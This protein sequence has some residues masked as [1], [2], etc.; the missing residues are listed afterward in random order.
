MRY[1]S[2]NRVSFDETIHGSSDFEFFD[3]DDEGDDD[4]IALDVPSDDDEEALVR[5]VKR[6]SPEPPRDPAVWLANSLMTRTEAALRLARHLLTSHLAAGDVR[7]CLSG[8][9]ALVRY[10]PRFPVVRFLKERGCE[11]AEAHHDRSTPAD[12]EWRGRY[13][14]KCVPHALVLHSELDGPDLVTPLAHGGRLIAHVNRGRLTTSRSPGEHKLLR[15]ALGRA[16]TYPYEPAD[17]GAAAVPRSQR[18]R[19]LAGEWRRAPA[20]T[21]A[22]LLILTVDRAGNVD[23]LESLQIGQ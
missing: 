7:L 21:R 22:G 10:R 16:L 11:L 14:M 9:E 23:G 8:R 20:V 3:D 6:A 17:I 13:V 1:E 19:T 5:P 15:A 4:D 18:Y 2:N 12:E